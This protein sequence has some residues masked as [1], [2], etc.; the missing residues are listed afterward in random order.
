MKKPARGTG[1]WKVGHLA[2]IPIYLH[3]SLPIPV[4]LFTTIQTIKYGWPAGSL[5]LISI[6]IAFLIVTLHELGHCLA[7]QAL[8]TRAKKITLTGIGGIAHIPI[9]DE[10]PKRD[11]LIV[12]AGPAV[13][14]GI[15]L[16]M[17]GMFGTPDLKAVAANPLNFFSGEGLYALAFTIN[18]ILLVFNLLPIYPMDGGRILKSLSHLFFGEAFS[19]ALVLSTCTLI[20]VP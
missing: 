10:N 11:L 4:L 1:L 2:K 17:L 15:L 13:N 9:K 5:P 20:G 3:W 7:A 19:T 14:V 6:T 16:L 12:A 18:L 8:N